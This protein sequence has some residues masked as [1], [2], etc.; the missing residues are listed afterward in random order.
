MPVSDIEGALGHLRLEF[1]FELRPQFLYRVEFA[2]VGGQPQGAEVAV[3]V[4][5]HCQGLD[6]RGM[7]IVDQHWPDVPER[8]LHLLQELHKV[9][10]VRRL[11]HIEH[12]ACQARPDCSVQRAFAYPFGVQLD[13]HLFRRP[14]PRMGLPQP[15]VEGGFVDINQRRAFRNK[16]AELAGIV[17]ALL[18]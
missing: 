18:F 9:H 13:V 16:S 12:G 1:G 14:L 5:T 10:F 17:P 7:V 3:D 2:A 6:V 4:F 8:S 11:A 15:G